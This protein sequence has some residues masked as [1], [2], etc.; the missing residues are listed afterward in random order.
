MDTQ[1]LTPEI[2]IGD[3]VER[4]ADFARVMAPPAGVV[5]ETEAE[6]YLEWVRRMA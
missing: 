3:A 6:S 1:T 4:P 5:V 2:V